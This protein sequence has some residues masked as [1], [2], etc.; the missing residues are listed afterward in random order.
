MQAIPRR[1]RF[2]MPHAWQAGK[3][4]ACWLESSDKAEHR[5]CARKLPARQKGCATLV[6]Q[7]M[8]EIAR[9]RPL[10]IIVA[11]LQHPAQCPA[12]APRIC[13]TCHQRPVLSHIIGCCAGSMAGHHPGRLRR[14]TA[15][16]HVSSTLLHRQGR[17]LTGRCWLVRRW[18]RRQSGPRP[19]EMGRSGCCCTAAGSGAGE[20]RQPRR[21]AASR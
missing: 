9:N 11:R 1:G 7:N 12:S 21:S 4:T 17:A 10:Q 19:P 6:P 20:S 18:E 2:I 15:M 3:V 5:T 14:K 13:P 16:L 8:G